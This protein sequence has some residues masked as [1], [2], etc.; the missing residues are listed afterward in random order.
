MAKII[1]EYCV[2]NDI[3]DYIANAI[4]TSLLSGRNID[5]MLLETS[6]QTLRNVKIVRCERLRDF[7]VLHQ[8][9]SQ[10]ERKNNHFINLDEKAFNKLC[11]ASSIVNIGETNK[12]LRSA[13]LITPKKVRA[14]TSELR[15]RLKSM[16]I[17][18]QMDKLQRTTR[19]PDGLVLGFSFK[20]ENLK[21]F[22][23]E[24]I[25]KH[26]SFMEQVHSLTLIGD[27]GR[28]SYKSVLVFNSMTK[29]VPASAA[30]L[31]YLGQDIKT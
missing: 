6:M 11:G 27:E 25:E 12:V 5:H 9:N 23:Q 21:L 17:S 8:E 16:L 7:L 18:H 31:I 15:N 30:I 1:W 4:Q 29:V 26:K 22:L 20:K 19:C 28:G 2:S 13:N 10:I 3:P 24:Y 14:K